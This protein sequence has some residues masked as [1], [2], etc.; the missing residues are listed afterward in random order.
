MKLM[1]TGKFEIFQSEKDNKYYFHLKAGNGEI[2]LASQG[3]TQK[4]SAEE[5]IASV[6]ANAAKEG[7]YEKKDSDDHYSFTLK[8][9]N[10]EVIGRSQVYQ[11]KSGRDNG[12]ESVMRNGASSE[13]VGS[14]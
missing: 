5:G 9:G 3:Y 13:V 12:I 8:A 7:N 2:I 11:S 14:R 6:K 1:S 4:H 10:G